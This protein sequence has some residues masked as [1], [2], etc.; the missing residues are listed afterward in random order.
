VLLYH[1]SYIEIKV[2]DLTYSRHNLDFGRGFYVT[3]LKEQAEK[4]AKR[5]AAMANL[6]NN[7]ESHEPIISVYELDFDKAELSVLSF[8]GYTEEWLDFVVSN[9]WSD[10]RSVDSE[11]DVIFGNIANDDVAAVV[12]DYMRLLSKG[13]LD[14]G[15]KQFYLNQLQFSK[16]NDQYCIVSEKALNA[17]TFVRS[18]IVKE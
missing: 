15:G 2:P 13:R 1:G 18:Y 8:G 7:I 17:L 12:D 14:S 16:P 6:L 10:E 4:W 11:Y 5:R 9:R 3:G